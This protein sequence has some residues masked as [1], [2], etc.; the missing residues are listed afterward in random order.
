M[1]LSSS[2]ICKH[3]E[4]KFIKIFNYNKKPNYEKN[5][6]IKGKYQRSF[7]QCKIC[8]HIY[9]AHKFSIKNLYS[10]QYLEL[11]YKNTNGIHRRFKEVTGLTKTKSDNK[12]RASRVNNF[13]S[14]HNPKVL[15]VGSGIGVFLFEMKKK[16]WQVTGV[17]MDKRYVDYCRKFHN[18]Q[19]YRKELSQ[20]KTKKKFDLITFNKVLEHVRNPTKLLNASKNFLNKNG[21]V[22]IEVPDI[23]AKTGG[24]NR[25]EF[26]IDHLHVF[27]VNSLKILA[28]KCGFKTLQIKTIHE[29]SGKYTLFAFL[30]K[31]RIK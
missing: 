18:L 19:I 25:Q 8:K 23:K 26:C 17:E 2:I 9:A 6:N 30:K 29:P 22:Y 31:L 28:E 1:R 3:D 5:F 4:N 24:K 7:Y 27:S 21:I 20:F 15:D 11:T 14:E 12:N 16:K 13:F 10:K